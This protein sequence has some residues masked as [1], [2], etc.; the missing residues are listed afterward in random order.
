MRNHLILLAAL[1]LAACAPEP[2]EPARANQ[3][4]SGVTGAERVRQPV[5]KAPWGPFR[6]V[7]LAD[8]SYTLNGEPMT[9]TELEA[10]LA[11]LGKLDPVPQVAMEAD[12]LATFHDVHVTAD[13]LMSHRMIGGPYP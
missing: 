2:P 7:I 4:V 10:R 11:R 9:R 3:P 13:L 8:G 12:E 6:L 1:A 5:S